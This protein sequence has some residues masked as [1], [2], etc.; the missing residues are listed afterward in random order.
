MA[1]QTA[2]GL[3]LRT[4]SLT[5]IHWVGIV[6]AAISGVIHLALGVSFIGD[7]L[8]WAFIIAGIGFLGG[9]IGVIVD[10]RRRL[11]YLVGIPFTAGQIV[12]WY[13][14]NAP[15]FSALG[16]GDKV[17]QV[18][19]IAVLIVLYRRGDATTGAT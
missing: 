3:S 5:G 4:E 7:P 14:V 9:I 1:T 10:Y 18:L 6:L 12:G 13:V 19:L 15:D 11:L 2:G 8:G 17:V 16:I